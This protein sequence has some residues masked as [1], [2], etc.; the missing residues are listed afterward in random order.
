MRESLHVRVAFR[1][2][3]IK[4]GVTSLAQAL[5]VSLDE[6]QSWMRS[7]APVPDG[8]LL[9]LL[10]MITDDTLVRIASG[11]GAEDE[12]PRNAGP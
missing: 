6:L 2:A 4:G 7:E 10:D 12:G 8:I 5:G 11:G 9:Q 3:Q 1:A